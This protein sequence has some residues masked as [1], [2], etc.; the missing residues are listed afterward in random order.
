[1]NLG[2]IIAQYRTDRGLSQRTLA[3]A[4]GASPSAIGLWESGT[5]I[6]SVKM[7]LMIAEVLGIP[8]L[9][10]LT[11]LAAMPGQA[12]VV[13]EPDLLAIVTIFRS[14]EPQ[15]RSRLFELFQ[16]LWAFRNET[17]HTTAA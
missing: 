2:K 3:D 6:P 10:L 16:A 1:M 4:I 17:A 7:R 15:Q 8:P 5:K 14:L 13:N 9:E 11:E 12:T